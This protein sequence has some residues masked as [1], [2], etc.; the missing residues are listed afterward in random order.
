MEIYKDEF[1]D[2]LSK[3][4]LKVAI[5]TVDSLLKYKKKKLKEQDKKVKELQEKYPYY[6]GYG[7]DMYRDDK[8]L[9]K[10]MVEDK[11]SLEKYLRKAKHI[12]NEKF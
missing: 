4:E 7:D 10:Y 6:Y 5:K 9:L 3:S 2:S 12:L 1:L 11:V 8:L